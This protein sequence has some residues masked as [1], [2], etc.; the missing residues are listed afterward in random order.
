[1]DLLLARQQLL[2]RDD[3]P[4]ITYLID[5]AALHRP[6]GRPGVMRAQLR[7]LADLAAHP[8][9]SVRVVPFTAGAYPHPGISHT[10]LDPR[11][12]SADAVYLETASGSVICRPGREEA[13][14]YRGYLDATHQKSV[15][16]RS[17]ELLTH[18]QTAGT[19]GGL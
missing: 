6:W 15:G 3:C 7:Q 9:I 4:H 18:V 12:G 14:R 10:L 17:S 16:I 11:G 13:D 1:V 2:D 8:R 19:N 5:E